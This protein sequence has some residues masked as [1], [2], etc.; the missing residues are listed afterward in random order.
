MNTYELHRFGHL[1]KPM[2]GYLFNV[3]LKRSSMERACDALHGL[4]IKSTLPEKLKNAFFL[5]LGR[6]RLELIPPDRAAFYLLTMAG[7]ND[8]RGRT[9]VLTFKP[10]NVDIS[11]CPSFK[12][13]RE[14]LQ[15]LKKAHM[16]WAL[17]DEGVVDIHLKGTEVNDLDGPSV[18]PLRPN[19]ITGWC[20][21]EW[22]GNDLQ[23]R[24]AI[25]EVKPGIQDSDACR[26]GTQASASQGEPVKDVHSLS[27]TTGLSGGKPTLKAPYSL[28]PEEQETAKKVAEDLERRRSHR[29]A[30]FDA[31]KEERQRIRE[32]QAKTQPTKKADSAATEPAK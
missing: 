29:K 26:E 23:S 18:L 9:P 13:L 5:F 4:H 2:P 10:G 19:E 14:S 20:H 27:D 24:E 1:S 31:I 15:K 8:E 21:R 30:F 32:S 22:T 11:G 7:F 3:S 25:A 28:T 16:I 6:W 12:R 17:D